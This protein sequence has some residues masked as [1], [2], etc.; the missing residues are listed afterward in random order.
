MNNLVQDLRFAFRMMG[1]RPGY[2]AAVILVLALGIGGTSAIFTV[3]NGVLL[4]PLPYK[5][6]DR[7]VFAGGLSQASGTD[8][9]A[10]W[11][12]AK[13]FEA[14]AT[15]RSGGANLGNGIQ[16]ERI[17]CAIVS[18]DFFR[19]FQIDAR[20]GRT[21]DEVFAE[22]NE[23]PA[24]V[25]SYGFWA[26]TFASDKGVIGK[27]VDLNG[28]FFTVVGI[29]PPGFGFP[30]H[31]SAWVPRA[32]EWKEDLDI[33]SDVQSDAG[34]SSATVG[35]LREGATLEEA[36]A[37]LKRLN[38]IQVEI[39]RAKQPRYAGGYVG[40]RPMK[41]F[42]IRDSSTGLWVLLG[43]VG[44]LLVIACVNVAHMLLVRAAA[45][46]KEV[47]V[48]LCMGASRGRILLQ[49][50]TE[51]MVLAL[52]GGAAG[53]LLSFA[54][55]RAIQAFGPKDVPRLADVNLDLRALGFALGLSLLIGVF[56]GFA[57]ALQIMAQ[58]LTR[59]LKQESSRSVGALRKGLRGAMIVAEVA[60]TLVLLMGAGLMIRSL[61]NLL[62]T[63]PGFTTLNTITMD[64]SLPRVKYAP[65]VPAQG[66]K[67]T[68]KET[69][70]AVNTTQGRVGDFYRQLSEGIGSLPGV[71]SASETE[72]LPLGG[73]GGGGLYLTAGNC[74]AIVQEMDVA[75]G[76]FRAMSIPVVAGRVF[77]AGDTEDAKFGIVISQAMARSCWPGGEAL[78]KS[79]ELFGGGLRE[80]SRDVIGIVGDVKFHGLGD[81]DVFAWGP[82]MAPGS[83]YYLPAKPLS[84]TL[85]V[86]A[87]S[88][89]KLLVAAIR[90]RIRKL[91]ADVPLYNIRTMNEVVSD[92]TAEPRFRG[93]ALGT[94]AVL[95]L[96][97]A[98][99]GL[100]SVV[101]YSVT[102]RTH[103]LG[104][105]MALGAQPRDILAMVTREGMWL[106]L[107]G[108]AVGAL[109][110]Y[111]TNKLLASF[112]YGVKPMDPATL[113][114][115]AGILA[116]GTMAACLLPARRASR[117]DPSCALRY[118]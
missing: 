22:A 35:R 60:L 31:T 47:A 95:A 63:P 109:G 51:S 118:E 92:A 97:L 14:L 30:G 72:R 34:G 13:S 115:V 39:E 91:D 96:V 56:V 66:S 55:V 46:Q 52:L 85:I 73:K 116:I 4:E 44:F 57:P 62:R 38:Q 76:Y 17:P 23:G 21:L 111:W 9:L 18:K 37:E 83:V 86:R 40:A 106:A 41:E 28:R 101:A 84:A 1:K 58:D 15:Y 90:E 112:L 27:Q 25:I 107:A 24:A 110:S 98:V 2:A 36:R 94:F 74:K 69:A 8:P 43:A 61:D 80:G 71:I 11:R 6:P 105:R 79:V 108:I 16:P 100:Y 117:T 64:F 99:F 59:A 103:E 70:P 19:V 93:I 53:T 42:M 102:C 50:L 87:V 88:D 68:F 33:G 89:P 29:M 20:F 49:L 82:G 45:R 3:V 26:R 113:A 10:W 78:G 75:S 12:Q 5:N 104:V 77:G 114:A 7:L 32:R 54:G 67:K 65:P 48:R 81:E